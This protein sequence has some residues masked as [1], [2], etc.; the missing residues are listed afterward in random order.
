MIKLRPH[1]GL[2]LNYFEGKGYSSDFE[3]HMQEV[4]DL[5]KKDTKICIADGADEICSACPNLQN[6]KCVSAEIV[7]HHDQAVLKKC[8]L[9]KGEELTYGEFQELVRGRILLPKKRR[10]ICGD[11]QWSSICDSYEI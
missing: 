6:G 10:E 4:S 2:C 8:G 5:L 7:D 1:H 3:R 11:C 9:E